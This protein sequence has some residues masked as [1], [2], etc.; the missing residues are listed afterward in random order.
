[1]TYEEA[2]AYIE[3]ISKAGSVL[4]LAGI[5]ALMQELGDVQ[6][7]LSVIHIAGTNG[8]GSVGAFI[9]SVLLEAGY[10]VG[11]YTSPAVFEPLEVWQINRKN[12]TKEEYLAC[13]GQ[14]KNACERMAEKGL[15]QPTVFEVETALAFVYFYQKKCDYVLVEVGMG[16]ET[17]ATNLITSPICAVITS[18]SMDHM[19]FLGNSLAEIARVKAGIIKEGCPVATNSGQ[20]PEVLTEIR[21]MAKQ[22]GAKLFLSGMSRVKQLQASL[23][24]ICFEYEG[25]GT[26]SIRMAGAYQ[27]ENAALA[28][29]VC[30]D[31]LKIRDEALLRGLNTAYWPGRF[32]VLSEKPLVILDGAHNED[33]AKKLARTIKLYFTNRKITYII[34]VLAD[35]EHKKMLSEM[36]PFADCVFTVT[37]LNGRALLGEVLKE[38][39]RTFGKEA[40]FCGTVEQVAELALKKTAEDGVIVAF[41]SLSYLAGLKRAFLELIRRSIRNGD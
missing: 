23:T 17:D 6:E 33:A 39:V 20:K 32:E 4:G 13:L 3:K 10:R 35:K 12:I 14:V 40:F 22:K 41:G 21:H 28:I 5:Q 16:G 26:V 27:V 1:M 34:G 37:P 15:P 18:I 2:R 25:L 36:L 30:K 31:I 7:Q 8:K 11:R 24:G 38:E 29:T 19:Q 9:E